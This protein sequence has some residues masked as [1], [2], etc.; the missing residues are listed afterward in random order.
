MGH[1]HT[2][3]ALAR[4]K[5]LLFNLASNPQAIG[6]LLAQEDEKGNKQPIY[7]AN[8]AL[9]GTETRYPKIERA[10]LVV[11]YASQ[12]LKCYFAVHQILLVT[13]SHPMKA[14]LH[15]SLLSRRVA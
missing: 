7:Y 14:L 1:L 6:A 4:G 5:P 9:K 15:Q 10:C 11:I 12:Q 13:R 3:Q 8:K 2:L